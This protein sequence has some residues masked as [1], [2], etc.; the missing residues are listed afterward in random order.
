VDVVHM[1]MDQDGPITADTTGGI[2]VSHDGRTVPDTLNV[3]LEYPRNW[4]CTFSNTPQAGLQ[5]D[6]I[7]FCGTQGHLRI[8]RTKYE[9]FGPEKDTVPVVVPCKTDL[10]EEHVQ[11]FLD[12]VRSRKLPNGDV[13]KGHRSAQAAHLANLSYTQRR[14]LNFDPEREIVL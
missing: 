8:D 11:N 13:Q 14:R 2:F 12:C 3:H 1:F 7:E 6:G 10:V 9:F 4:I 5:R